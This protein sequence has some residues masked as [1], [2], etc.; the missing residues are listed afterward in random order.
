[1]SVE[2]AAKAIGGCPCPVVITS[3]AGLVTVEHAHRHGCPNLYRMMRR[4]AS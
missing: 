3:R 2:D 1:M 4:E